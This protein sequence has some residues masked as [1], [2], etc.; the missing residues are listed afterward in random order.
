MTISS[1]PFASELVSMLKKRELSALELLEATTARIERVNPRINAIV[2]LELEAARKRAVQIDEARV[3]GGELG[4]LA[5][6]PLAIKDT[7]PTK[8]IR[9]TFG[10]PV[11][12]DLIPDQNSAMVERLVAAGAIIIGKTNVPEFALGSHTF[13]P[14]FGAT[15]NPW[16]IALSAG[17]SSGGA[18]A[19]VASG[20]LPFADGTDFGGSL[21][22]PGSFNN[23][24]GLRTSAGRVARYPSHDAYAGVSVG[25]PL[26]RSAADA[27][28][29]L[30]VMAGPDRRDPLS[31][32]VDG[33]SFLAPLERDFKGVRIAYS[34]TLGGLPVEAEVAAATRRGLAR[35]EQLGAVVEQA[36][37]DLAG[38]DHAFETL[39]ALGMASQYGTLLKSRRHDLKDTAVWNIEAGLR[40][41]IDDISRA[42]AS[43]TRL[44]HSMRRFLEQYDY[45]VAPVS[46]V[47][48]FALELAYPQAIE[49]Q[50]MENY[51]AWMRSCSRI[52]ITGHPA[53]SVPGDF[54][55]TGMPVGLQVIARMQDE[56]SL[57]QLAHALE[58][59]GDVARRRPPEQMAGS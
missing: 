27:A 11:Y 37:P 15:R 52:T 32:P 39:R 14:I 48:P 17:G 30:S 49:G 34:A 53:M 2:S 29:L 55:S 3:H 51:L 22:N 7:E 18:A 40:L 31:I 36:E 56:W 10:S 44:Y 46:Q 26:A 57:L 23:L 50:P 5:G 25:G 45:L 35:L 24:L 42:S 21:R 38:A 4:P 1:H 58:Q 41:S 47:S 8:G 9:T 28:L 19:G 33:A 6:L 20:M 54:T 59:V 16:N 13:N 12:R 43:R